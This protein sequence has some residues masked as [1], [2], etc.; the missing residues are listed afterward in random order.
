LYRNKRSEALGLFTFYTMLRSA[1][2]IA[3]TAV[4][5]GGPFVNGTCDPDRLC[6]REYVRQSSVTGRYLD[7]PLNPHHRAGDLDKYAGL[8]DGGLVNSTARALLYNG[9]TAGFPV[10]A[11]HNPIGR[12]R[13]DLA[14]GKRI[15]TLESTGMP[16]NVSV[17]RLA[18]VLTDFEFS[19]VL[20]EHYFR[21]HGCNLEPMYGDPVLWA[22]LGPLDRDTFVQMH[23]LSDH[24]GSD[25]V[26]T[27]AAGTRMRLD[28]FYE[29][30]RLYLH[31]A[32]SDIINI[33]PRDIDDVYT[34]L[35]RML[36]PPSGL[37]A[38]TIEQ[39]VGDSKLRS[40]GNWG[41]ILR[42]AFVEAGGTPGEHNPDAVLSVVNQLHEA[43]K[44]RYMVEPE[45]G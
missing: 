3:N 28:E 15:C 4:L 34:S 31:R 19:H 18:A 12:L 44:S 26:L 29:M 2:A 14:T 1:T 5:K 22:I 35:N 8:L 36:A 24:Q 32:L 30:K 21:Q 39:F 10:S 37:V 23:N 17:S 43:M 7:M 38:Q 9:D 40:T 16:A 25:M 45:L 33:T 41:Q 13:P 27:T 20:I 42:N 6:V 11:M